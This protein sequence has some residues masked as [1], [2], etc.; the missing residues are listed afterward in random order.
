MYTVNK[1][2]SIYWLIKL[3]NINQ[4][5]ISDAGLRPIYYVN[6][7]QLDQSIQ[8]RG[9][10]IWHNT[11]SQP[12]N[13]SWHPPWRNL[14]SQKKFL[15]PYKIFDAE[16]LDPYKKIPPVTGCLYVS[17]FRS[18]RLLH[19]GNRDIDEEIREIFRN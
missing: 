6:E 4:T 3:T 5:H 19:S 13:N 14:W 11:I 18:L 8:K 9:R 2:W 15:D 17:L 12:T 1:F 7:G 16:I 10:F